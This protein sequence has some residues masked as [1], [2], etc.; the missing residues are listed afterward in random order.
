V[1]IG[2]V[3]AASSIPPTIFLDF[4]RILLDLMH[5]PYADHDYTFFRTDGVHDR[6][7]IVP[8]ITRVLDQIRFFDAA[9]A[10]YKRGRLPP[11]VEYRPA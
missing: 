3:A 9:V 6:S 5:K 7:L 4:V 11:L 10:L 8:Y 1:S 2:V